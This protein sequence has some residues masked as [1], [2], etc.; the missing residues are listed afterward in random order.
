MFEKITTKKLVFMALMVALNI[1]L[2]R[3]VG[4][5][6]DQSLRIDF[7]Y[8]SN[9]M[10]GIVLGPVLGGVT[11]AVSDILGVILSGQIGT[12]FPLFTLNSIFYGVTY[13]LFL[14]KKEKSWLNIS[15][16]IVTTLLVGGIILYPVWMYLFF[17]IILKKQAVY[18]AILASSTVKNIIFLPI[19]IV[20]VK[21][22]STSLLPHIKAFTDEK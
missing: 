6:V 3:F 9:V 1:V 12:Y 8:L 11:A 5:N 13:G 19:Q 22:I 4:I 17:Q 18:I 14:H 20:T 7:G 2:V 21:F 15:I 10:A 16:C